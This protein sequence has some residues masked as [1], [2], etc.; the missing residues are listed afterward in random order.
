[1]VSK[2]KEIVWKA[3]ELGKHE[4]P[5]YLL[6]KKENKKAVQKVFRKILASY[7]G[8][9]K[10][11][12]SVKVRGDALLMKVTSGEREKS[13]DVVFKK[14]DGLQNFLNKWAANDFSLTETMKNERVRFWKSGSR[15]YPNDCT[16]TQHLVRQV[17]EFRSERAVD[18]G[19][20]EEACDD[21]ER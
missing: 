1:M 17:R 4:Y 5:D 10:D 6:D 14:S 19:H 2:E 12:L 21:Y 20:Q 8:V 9:D 18:E 16:S 7:L 3:K 15:D 11:D 13:Y